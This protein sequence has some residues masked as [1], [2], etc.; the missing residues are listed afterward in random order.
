M[1]DK[2]CKAKLSNEL[3][4]QYSNGELGGENGEYKMGGSKDRR[5]KDI[6]IADDIALLAENE[7]EKHDRKAGGISG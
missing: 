3:V 5:E 7:N 4:I 6:H 2:K 1:D